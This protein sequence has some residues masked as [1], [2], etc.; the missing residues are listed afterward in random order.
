MFGMVIERIFIPD[1]AKVSSQMNRKIVA[2]GLS[3]ILTQCP[4]M[5]TAP[6]VQAWPRLLQA[7]IELFEL[8]PFA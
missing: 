6:Y 2:V 4:R 7:L 5:L 3:K 1:M 8:P